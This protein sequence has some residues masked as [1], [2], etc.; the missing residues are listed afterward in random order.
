MQ[1]EPVR[2]LVKHGEVQ[3]EVLT[4]GSGPLIVMLPSGGRGASDFDD[5]ARRLATERFRV[6]CPEPRGIGRSIAPVSGV[7]LHDF[8]N[9]VAAVIKHEGSVRAVVVGHAYG[10]WV[11]RMTAADHPDLVRGVVILAAGMK[12]YPKEIGDAVVK[13]AQAL[14]AQERLKYL[15]IAFFAAGNDPS[16]W[17]GGWYPEVMHAQHQA[18][19]AVASDDYWTAGKAPVL[20]LLAADDP[21]RPPASRQDIQRDLGGDRVTVR[22][23]ANAS[24]SIVPEQPAAVV[25]EIAAWVKALPQS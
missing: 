12:D 24:H 10:N 14:P 11:A 9:D 16:P 21:F 1:S 25:R 4:R 18:S 17:L 22:V 5:V 8:A 20:D 23:I 3:I 15:R 13:C 19:L 7:T 6:A 2:E